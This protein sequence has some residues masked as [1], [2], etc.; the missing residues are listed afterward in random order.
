[1]STSSD[2]QDRLELSE[3]L[4]VAD[5]RLAHL[6]RVVERERAAREARRDLQRLASASV[7][8]ATIDQLLSTIVRGAADVLGS[9]M[10]SV[11][12]PTEGDRVRFVHVAG[13]PED[14]VADWSTA[15]RD[16]PVPLV[17]AL[18][19]DA[20]WI[21]LADRDAMADWPLLLAEAD[22]ADINSYLAVPLRSRASR[23]PIA[24]LGIGFRTEIRFD[25]LDRALVAELSELAADALERAAQ[26]EHARMVAE[27]L[28][29]A[30]LPRRLPSV[31]G[32]MLRSLYQPS[33]DLTE[34]G[35]DWYDVVRLH[36]GSVALVVG[37]VAGHDIS[38][39]AEMGRIRHVLASHLVEHVDPSTAL[40]LTDQYF[41][42]ID[43]GAFATAV[44]MVLDPERTSMALASAGHLPPFRIRPDSVERLVIPPGPPI[45]SGLGGY[46]CG[47]EDVHLGDTLVAF[48]DG[49]VERRDRPIDDCLDELAALLD[50][51]TDR[52][53][54][55]LVRALREHLD[56]PDRTDDAA[57][58]L[59]TLVAPRQV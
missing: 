26:L 22:R 41:A 8:A 2:E 3:L 50:R 51:C 4:R 43:D 58:L 28:Q 13:I 16:T 40:T 14:L 32:L 27:A 47:E 19:H 54:A 35:G 1:M 6:T 39:A 5:L 46:T 15:T 20:T 49:V 34:V 10:T 53:P 29:H 33:A 9:H 25:S 37:D 44:V 57:V 17:Q 59:A 30:L 31:S 56:S 21:E 42:M 45:G 38:S 24:A 48:T 55:S 36:D 12:I 7:A 23:E 11:V 52:T 18:D